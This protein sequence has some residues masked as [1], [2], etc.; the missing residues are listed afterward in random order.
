MRL[1]HTSDIHLDSPLTS[2]LSP[3]KARER[4][5]ELVASFRRMTE[6]ATKLGAVGIIIAGDLFDS[7]LV[8]ARAMDA[9][10]G[11][12]ESASELTF[13]Y[14]VGN[15]EKD[16]LTSSGVTLPK[17]LL[18]FGEEWTYFK[19]G[20]VNIAGRT[21]ITRDM[22]ASLSLKENEKNIVVLHGEL[23]DRGD[24]AERIGVR[25]AADLP[26]DY[27]ALGHYHT[28]S[29]REISE[30]GVAVYSG[31]PE[32]RGFDE[33]GDKG[34]VLIDTDGE[35][36]RHR[37][38]KRAERTLYEIEV[39]ISG[40]EREIEIEDRIARALSVADGRDIIR[41]VLTGKHEPYVRRDTESLELRFSQKYFYLEVKD[42]SKLRISP[43]EYKNDKT[44]KGEFIR[45]VMAKDEL[46]DEERYA[47][48]EC[49]IRA[50]AGESI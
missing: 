37:F 31:T 9:F 15:H 10:I 30:R 41:V 29:E 44:L 28:Y 26:I 20:D 43:E 46:T 1:I 23:A 21:R 19:F 38:I 12:V 25:D 50:L 14:L 48:I 4:K 7:E 40:A 3:A 24:D 49:G 11:I 17:N 32:G 35:F 33:T 34:Y 45:H 6:E 2:R 5:R 13:F 36:I 8:G 27:L 16:R 22:F 39:D 42:K 18:V 47:I